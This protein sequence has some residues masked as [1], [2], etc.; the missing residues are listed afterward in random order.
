MKLIHTILMILAGCLPCQAGDGKS[1]NLPPIAIHEIE[2]RGN[3]VRE[4]GSSIQA[5]EADAV[6]EALAPPASDADKWY[7]TLVVQPN[8]PPCER[9][10]ADL[11]SSPALKAWVDVQSPKDSHVH[12]QARNVSDATQAGW[13]VSLKERL[14]EGGF[15]AIVIQPPRSGEYGDAKTVVA[16]IHGYDG[17]AKALVAKLRDKVAAYVKTLHKKGLISRKAP[18]ADSYVAIGGKPPFDVDESKNDPLVPSGP[19]DW[20]PPQMLTLAQIQAA[21]PKADSDFILQTLAAQELA[22]QPFT[23]E[24]VQQAWKEES[25]L[26]PADP[27]EIDLNFHPAQPTKLGNGVLI[28]IVLGLTAMTSLIGYGLYRYRS[29]ILKSKSGPIKAK[30]TV[31]R[32]SIKGEPTAQPD[33]IR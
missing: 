15:P 25:K 22:K 3:A 1:G 33:P 26:V 16:M 13:L 2:R 31:K 20:P 12:Y 5:S 30:R 29:P 23:I 18:A 7:V 10:K 32:K 28:V 4:L 14:D 27:P 6:I 19:H 8:C 21:V 17:N 24:D 9:L 11:I